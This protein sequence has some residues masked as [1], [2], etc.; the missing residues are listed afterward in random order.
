MSGEA[1]GR[2]GLSRTPVDDDWGQIY[3]F[4]PAARLVRVAH[5][6]CRPFI[7]P[8]ALV[9]AKIMGGGFRESAQA[10]LNRLV[11]LVEQP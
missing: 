11:E 5:E 9:W 8:L 7:G 2:G 10:D 1:V 6:T 4:L 3:A